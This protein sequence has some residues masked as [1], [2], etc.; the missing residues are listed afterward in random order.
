MRLNE[1]EKKTKHQFHGKSHGKEAYT[2]DVVLSHSDIMKEKSIKVPIGYD[3]DASRAE[4][5]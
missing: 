3:L 5:E 2:L 1:K 4:S